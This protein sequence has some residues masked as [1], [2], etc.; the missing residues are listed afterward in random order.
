VI[1]VAAE[2]DRK[3][4]R[5]Q[6]SGFLDLA[7]VA[8]F[9]RQEQEAVRSMGL[10]SGEFYLLVHT[11]EAVIQSQEVVAAFQ[12]LITDS[13]F[14]AKRIAVARESSLTRI[15]TNRIVKIRDNAAVFESLADAERWLFEDSAQDGSLK[16]Q[17]LSRQAPYSAVY[18]VPGIAS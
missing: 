4:V 12:H 15:Q 13:K 8:E 9:S 17:Q 6:M 5:A 2:P 16:T 1:T 11:S 7:E 18:P 10:G 3:L 14:K